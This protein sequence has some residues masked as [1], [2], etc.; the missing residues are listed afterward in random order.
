MK[1]RARLHY[2]GSPMIWREFSG[3][4]FRSALH[5]RRM[6]D[7]GDV[8]GGS[9]EQGTS[10]NCDELRDLPHCSPRARLR[11]FRANATI[12]A[13]GIDKLRQHPAEVLLSWAAC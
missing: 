7:K 6:F 5:P 2:R 3:S 13:L 10:E 8:D 12:C 1:S 11:P 4:D 9:G